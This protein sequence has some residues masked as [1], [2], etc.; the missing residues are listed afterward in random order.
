MN[1]KQLKN[2]YTFGNLAILFQAQRFKNSLTNNKMKPSQHQGDFVQAI[3]LP[4]DAI[5][6]G[7]IKGLKLADIEDKACSKVC[8]HNQKNNGTCYVNNEINTG[9]KSAHKLLKNP[10]LVQEQVLLNPMFRFTVFGDIGRLNSKGKEFILSLC[11]DDYKRL[12]YTADFHKK[13]MQPFKPYFMASIQSIPQ[14]LKAVSLGW[15]CYISDKASYLYAK[16]VLKLRLY[17]C[18]VDNDG[19]NQVFGCSTCPIQCDAQRHVVARNCFKG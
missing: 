10:H 6:H 2:F 9:L 17:K 3:I 1:I 4:L 13:S 11:N 15:T 5:K 19:L 18:P 12:A 8:L 7:S 16:D 14:L